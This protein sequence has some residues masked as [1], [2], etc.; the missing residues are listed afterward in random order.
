MTYNNG[1]ETKEMKVN[2]M[3]NNSEKTFGNIKKNRICLCN[4]R[5]ELK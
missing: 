1:T 4:I 3:G 5:R 2:I